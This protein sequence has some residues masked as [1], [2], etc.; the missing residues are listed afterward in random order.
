MLYNCLAQNY[1]RPHTT[2]H[3]TA[4]TH[5]HTDLVG[6]DGV[7]VLLGKHPGEGDSDGEGYDGNDEGILEGGTNEP[8][9]QD[10]HRGRAE[11][12]RRGEGRLGEMQT[13][14]KMIP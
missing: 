5:A 2:Q 11:V 13:V 6:T 9:R 3:H 4:R 1:G 7:V 14:Q 12:G 8:R 10:R